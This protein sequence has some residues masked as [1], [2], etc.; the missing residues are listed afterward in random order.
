MSDKS[1]WKP[2]Q[3]PDLSSLP[4]SFGLWMGFQE[5]AL[6]QIT[7]CIPLDNTELLGTNE[8]KTPQY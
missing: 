3:K 6:H 1:L 5:F 8:I 2:I 4:G 7:Q